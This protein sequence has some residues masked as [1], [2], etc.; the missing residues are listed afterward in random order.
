MWVL[1]YFRKDSWYHTVQ[2]SNMSHEHCVFK[3]SKPSFL[4]NFWFSGSHAGTQRT[5]KHSLLNT[6]QILSS[7]DESQPISNGKVLILFH[8]LVLL[9]N[10]RF[11]WAV[12]AC[13]HWIGRGIGLV[14]VFWFQLF[15]SRWRCQQ[16]NYS[17]KNFGI[18]KQLNICGWRTKYWAK[19]F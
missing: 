13:D 14:F 18:T 2:V 3:L 17:S 7:R 1:Q 5:S 11:E 15:Y 4:L 19:E 10:I 8:R 6:K 12:L 9:Y 16:I